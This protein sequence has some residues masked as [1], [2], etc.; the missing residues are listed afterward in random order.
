[1]V[2]TQLLETEME[3]AKMPAF[4][5]HYGS[6]ATLDLPRRLSQAR[7]VSIPLWFLRNEEGRNDGMR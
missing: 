7:R 1:M 5:Y 4:P 6:Y 3:G 2:L